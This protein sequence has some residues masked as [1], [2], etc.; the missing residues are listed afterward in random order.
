MPFL[1]S[2]DG[3]IYR[4]HMVKKIHKTFIISNEYVQQRLDQTL[5]KLMPDYSRTQIK[6]WITSGC[7]LVSSDLAPSKFRLKGNEKITI[8]IHL[9]PQTQVEPQPIPLSI[10]YEDSELLII[11]KPASLVVHP[12]PGNRDQT[13]LNAL[14]F[15]DSTLAE[16]PRAG[17]LHRL[18]K[19][20]T[21]L[22]VIAKT[23]KS[24]KNLASQLKNHTL[25]REYQAVVY[26]N[27]ISGGTIRAPIG[28]HPIQRKRMAVIETAKP[29]ITHYRVIEKFRAHTLLKVQLE[30]GRTHQIRVH[31]AHLY[32]PIVGDTTYGGRIQ[33]AKQSTPALI[34]T[35]QQ[36]KRQ[37]LH[38]YAIELTHPALHKVMRWQADLPH[39]MQE[40]IQQL[41]EDR[42]LHST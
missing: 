34:Q 16:L 19:N 39:D 1:V 22:L 28:R 29:A 7:I 23:A 8:E 18:D 12:G 26:G 3:S 40:L 37:A 2:R 24:L 6:E 30:T 36:F 38:A 11:N 9:L 42:D 21:G 25:L 32:H 13:L 4:I 5:A 31:M 17:I 35:L 33:F 20:T 27:I 15:H 14:L 10:V 41:R